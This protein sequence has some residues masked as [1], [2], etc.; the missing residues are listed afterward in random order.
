MIVARRARNWLISPL[1]IVAVA[2]IAVSVAGATP[3][4]GSQGTDT[5]LPATDSEVTVSGRGAFAG[6]AITVNQTRNLTNQA[7]SITWTGGTPTRGPGRFG[8]DY[9]QIMQCWGDDDGTV[10]GNP[11]PPPE[12]CEQGAVG[13]TPGGNGGSGDAFPK[14]LSYSRVI[15]KS[16]Y[17]N[18]ASFAP[19]IAN[20]QAYLDDRTGLVWRP[21]RSVSGTVVNNETDP[22][23]NPSVVGGNFWLNSFFDIVTTNEIIGAVTGSDGRG[24]DVLQV[25][26]GLQS[27]GLGCGRKVQPLPNGSKTVPKCWIVVV[28]R[29]APLD[30]NVGTPSATFDQDGV[31]TSPLSPAAWQNRIA[32]PIEFNPVDPSCS[33]GNDERRLSGNELAQP[34]VTSWQPSLCAGNAQPPFN[35]SP[36][37]DATAR[38]QLSVGAQGGPGM[39]VVSRPFS[40]GSFAASNPVVYSPLSVSGLVIGFNVE[41]VASLT[42]PPEESALAGVR[43]AELNLTP[44]LVAKLLTQS[45]SGQLEILGSQPAGYGWLTGNPR[46]LGADP[47]FLQFNPEFNL[48]QVQQSRSFSGLS[49]PAG[50]S[51]A[52]REVW[53]W[54]LADPEAKAWLDGAADPWGMRINPAFST[55]P[56][57]N[58]L[59]V[60]FDNPTPSSFP[61]ND[62]YCYQAPTRTS[63]GVAV[64]PPQLCGTDWMPF[65]RSLGE[66]AQWTRSASDGARIVDNSFA[67]AASDVWKK[68]VP[69]QLGSRAMLSLTDTPAAYRFGLQ[70]ARLSQA[71]DNGPNRTFVAPDTAGLLA[72]LTTMKPGTEPAVLEPSPDTSAPRAYP[73]TAITYAAIAPLALDAQERA[74]FAAF[75]DYATGPGQVPGLHLGQLP[76]G[77]VP[78]SSSMKAQ[79]TSAASTIRDLVPPPTPTTTTTTTTTTVAPTLTNPATTAQLPPTVPPA[80]PSRST[81]RAATSTTTTS[82]TLPPTTTVAPT[83]TVPA[84]TTVAPATTVAPTTTVAASDSTH[85]TP[86]LTVGR[87]RLAVPGIG[88]IAVLSALGAL[89]ITKRPRRS[90][91]SEADDPAATDGD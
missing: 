16:S 12:Q 41:R 83:T 24:A 59:G 77:Y 69:Q 23:F 39:V 29:G 6:L 48:L 17:D 88:V 19:L 46:Q 68:D 44:R 10:P 74:D 86:G 20:G 82:T 34:A 90:L 32:I 40:S 35:Y 72:G 58:S 91:L 79:A 14:G 43:V 31:V 30:E 11:G 25:L 85:R 27:S 21:F 36:I 2:T 65:A 18:F 73:L 78:L 1:A 26:T 50:N 71:G 42:A 70:T 3:V 84:T 8:G 75:I 66:A 57:I 53:E 15:T 89:E 49:L 55:N 5:S 37:S 47:D 61:K 87:N 80:V 13:G 33:L 4:P 28:P 52:A 76:P 63:N 45:Y 67:V 7:V 51:D 62:P 64:V 9:L 54:I 22:N 38:Q 81:S 60:A 56:A